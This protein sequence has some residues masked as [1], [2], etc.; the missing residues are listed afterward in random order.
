MDRW[1]CS[2]SHEWS[3]NPRLQCHVWEQTHSWAVARCSKFQTAS[4][5]RT[6]GLSALRDRVRHLLLFLVVVFYCCCCY[7]CRFAIKLRSDTLEGVVRSSWDLC[8]MLSSPL[9]WQGW[10]LERAQGRD[11]WFE[12]LGVAAIA[13]DCLGSEINVHTNMPAMH[14]CAETGSWALGRIC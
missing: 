13:L 1:L 12:F 11:L 3:L 7:G 6:L 2:S 8:I 14:V 5:V 4:A 9:V 10:S